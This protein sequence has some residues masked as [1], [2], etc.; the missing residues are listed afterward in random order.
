M[1]YD[2]FQKKMEK[3]EHGDG[4]SIGA[5]FTGEYTLY[6]FLVMS[7]VLLFRLFSDILFVIMGISVIGLTLSVMP[8]LFKFGEENSNHI[9]MQL[10]WISIFVGILSVVIYFAK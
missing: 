10:F 3:K 6:G 1:D 7:I 5:G 4:V 2:S 9:N 8:L